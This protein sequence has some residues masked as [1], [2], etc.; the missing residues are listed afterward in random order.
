M[1]SKSC[2]HCSLR[3]SHI[4]VS[5]GASRAYNIGGL[6]VCVFG[7]GE[8]FVVLIRCDSGFPGHS[9][10][11]LAARCGTC[12]RVAIEVRGYWD[13]YLKCGLWW[14]WKLSQFRSDE[15]LRQ[16]PWLF[17]AEARCCSSL[18][19]GFRVCLSCLISRSGVYSI[20][21]NVSYFGMICLSFLASV[22]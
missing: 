17:E 12:C 5:F 19:L 15:F 21:R 3:L 22:V 20:T 13:V 4:L 11:A 16:V 7:G 9:P 10:A 14:V 18:W 2:A 1:A 8:G 6:T